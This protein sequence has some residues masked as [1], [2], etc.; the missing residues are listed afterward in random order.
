M[1]TF[2]VFILAAITIAG[3]SNS[4]SS[5]TEGANGE[6]IFTYQPLN[7]Q[8][9]TP[10]KWYILN[11]DELRHKTYASQQFYEHDKE[12][13][14]DANKIIFGMN[15]EEGKQANSLYAFISGNVTDHKVA[16][17]AILDQQYAQ[18]TEPLSG[19]DDYTVDSTFRQKEINQKTFYIATLKVQAPNGGYYEYITYSTMLD[20]LN[21]GASIICTN[22]QDKQLL[23]DLWQ[24]SIATVKP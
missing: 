13:D 22:E 6:M 2:L 8:I 4:D 21:F 24:R 11:D 12:E 17:K 5:I 1:R 7:W 16:L 19:Y 15:K 14:S 10:Q 23:Q 20:T 18:Y 9:N 3:C